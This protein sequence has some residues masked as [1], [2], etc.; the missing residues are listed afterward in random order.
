M[1]GG[2]G[3]GRSPCCSG[4]CPLSRPEAQRHGDQPTSRPLCSG[5]CSSPELGTH[6]PP[7]PLSQPG[8]S[9]APKT[10]RRTQV[11]RETRRSG[12]GSRGRRRPAGSSQLYIR[13]TGQSSGLLCADRAAPVWA[14]PAGLPATRR[15]SLKRSPELGPRKERTAGAARGGVRQARPRLRRAQ[16]APPPHGQHPRSSGFLQGHPCQTRLH[17]G[18]LGQGPLRQEVPAASARPPETEPVSLSDPTPGRQERERGYAGRRSAATPPGASHA[19]PVLGHPASGPQRPSAPRGSGGPR[20]PSGVSGVRG[21]V[22]GLRGPHARTAGRRVRGWQRG[23]PTG[24]RGSEAPGRPTTRRDRPPSRAAAPAPRSAR[25]P[26]DQERLRHRATLRAAPTPRPR[27]AL[28]RV[29]RRPRPEARPAERQAL[30]GAAQPR[31]AVPRRRRG[32]RLSPGRP[33]LAR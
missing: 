4:R 27:P 22:R 24:L 2:A 26:A 17:L 30:P 31:P 32:A 29:A 10:S 12:G 28:A 5:L 18:S 8:A 9:R 14:R 16:T 33:C 20:G 11:L 7:G 6:P 21:A 15:A 13:G 23:A 19:S 3:C 25:S 1:A